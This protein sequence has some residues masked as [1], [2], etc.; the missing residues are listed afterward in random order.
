MYL[1]L[2]PSDQ[3]VKQSASVVLFRCYELPY[4]GVSAIKFV[5]GRS[6]EARREKHIQ[7]FDMF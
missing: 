7:T 6:A 4:K 1:V 3:K 5:L 2:I